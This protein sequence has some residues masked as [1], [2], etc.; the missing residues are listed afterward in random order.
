MHGWEGVFQTHGTH[1]KRLEHVSR[2]ACLTSASDAF[3]PSSG[4]IT[5]PIGLTTRPRG[6]SRLLGKTTGLIDEVKGRDSVDSG[7]TGIGGKITHDEEGIMRTTL[8]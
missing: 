4:A 8:Y 2:D 1:T 7:S 5:L 3:S 6:F